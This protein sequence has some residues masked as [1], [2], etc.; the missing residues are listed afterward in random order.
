MAGRIRTTLVALAGAALVSRAAS[1]QA[2][3]PRRWTIGMAAEYGAPAG[4]VQV[5]E[6]G[7][8]G[9]R[10][11]LRPDLGVRSTHTF[12][13]DVALPASDRAA[14]RLSIESLAL[15]GAVT[16]PRDV[17]FNGATLQGGTRLTTATHFPSFV[18]ATAAWERRLA[19][20]AGGR[21]DATLGLTFDFLTFELH[22]TLAPGSNT[23]ETREDFLT[24]ELP[25]PLVGLRL[26]RPLGGRVSLRVE[27]DGGWLPR[28]NSLRREGGTVTLE[29]R[30]GD[31]G[32]DIVV[33]VGR[34][35]SLTGGGRL[36]WYE[37][38]E[39]SREDGNRISLR[40]A[41]LRAGAALR[42]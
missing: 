32:A 18:R 29:Q 7:L 33:A 15:D 35:T 21:L 41:A 31:L 28:V 19:R 10:L 37:Q 11:R 3:A 36:R 24:Q 20:P 14:W 1:A 2:D 16:L 23:R 39:Q 22:G 30:Q 26:E 38:D 13:L 6:G 42:L 8:E 40:S 25:V 27:A 17:L 9:T 5:R 4:W 12:A 34:R